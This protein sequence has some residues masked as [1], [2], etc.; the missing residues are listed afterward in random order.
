MV[1]ETA[2]LQLVVERG[3][4]LVDIAERARRIDAAGARVDVRWMGADRQQHGRERTRVVAFVEPLFEAGEQRRVLGRAE[5]RARGFLADGIL[6]ITG[7]HRSM[8]P[9]VGDEYRRF[10]E[11]AFARVPLIVAGA[12]DLP[13]V[14]D[15]P[16]QQSDLPA[17]LARLYG[18]EYCRS[19]FAGTFLGELSPPRYVVH[20]RGDNRDRVDVYTGEA[21]ASYRQR[22]D[23]SR[24]EDG[25][26]VRLTQNLLQT[27][28]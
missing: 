11:R 9:L 18:V 14:V 27:G 10:G 7:D 21:T 24:W 25:V 17:S 6:L 5:L 19:P 15:A 16:F 2:L 3:E 22:G 13:A 26:A 23:A 20:A 1:E 8:T 4:L 12:V 28:R